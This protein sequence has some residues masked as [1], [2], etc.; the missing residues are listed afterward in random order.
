MR[1]WGVARYLLIV[2]KLDRAHVKLNSSYEELEALLN[3]KVPSN[4]PSSHDGSNCV[5]KVDPSTS[6]HDLLTM[7]CPSS[8]DNISTLETNLLKK[9]ERLKIDNAKLVDRWKRY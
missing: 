2:F 9:N 6:C 7:P 1:R 5:V 3:E 8:C 4:T